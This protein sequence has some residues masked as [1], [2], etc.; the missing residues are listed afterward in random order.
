[1]S[2]GAFAKA[3]Y[4]ADTGL[5]FGILIQPET[6]TLILNGVTNTRPAGAKTPGLPRALVGGSRRRRGAF[7]RLVR[8]KF[9]GTVPDGYLGGNS[10]LTLPVLTQSMFNGLD[11]DQTG[12][13]TINGTAYDVIYIGKSPER[14]R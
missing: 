4:E 5:I 9:T 7:T 13:Y 6:E 2:A 10:A 1:M 14:V 3:K 11:E 12:T 8:F